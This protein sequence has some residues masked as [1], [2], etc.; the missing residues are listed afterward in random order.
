MPHVKFMRPSTVL[1]TLPSTESTPH[2]LDQLS[3][4]EITQAAALAT[5][6]ATS[7]SKPS[8]RFNTITLAVRYTKHARKTPSTSIPKEPTKAQLIAFNKS[9]TVPPR[10]AFCI[11]QFPPSLDIVEATID[12]P[13][14]KVLQWINVPNAQ[15]VATP[16][17]CFAA[18]A[19]AKQDETVKKLLAA[20]GI[21]DTD[22]VACDPWCGVVV[23]HAAVVATGLLC[24]YA[25]FKCMWHPVPSDEPVVCCRAVA[26]AQVGAPCPL[27]WSVDPNLYVPS[28][29]P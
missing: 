6:Y 15:P 2:P 1:T 26:P 28:I 19:I 22:L 9:G 29:P 23:D 13:A 24:Q 11:L 21:T 3:A 27:P 7:V 10:C 16:D 25:R 5:K 14:G 18:E 12:L 17:D 20:R 4:A 8:P